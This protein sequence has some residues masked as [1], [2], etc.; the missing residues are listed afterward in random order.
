M[1]SS[2]RSLKRAKSLQEQTYLAIRNSILSGEITP[3]ERL[4]ETQL[5]KKLQVSRTP[6]REAIKQLQRETLAIADHNGGIRVATISVT[7]AQQLY[8]CRIALE[9]LAVKEVCQQGTAA[10]IKKIEIWVEKAEHISEDEVLTKDQSLQMLEIDYQFHLAIV[11]AANNKWLVY[12]LDQ[13]FDKMKLL[14]IQTTQ[15]NPKVLEIRT[16]HRQVYNAISQRNTK[17]AIDL[18]TKHLRASK[19]R[20]VKELEN[21]NSKSLDI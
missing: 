17:Q 12:L 18:I 14:R 20:V 6:V 10:Q 5:A 13:V 1:S 8:D 16:E 9:E 11:E 2:L 3:G 4:I 21:I 7:D 19:K 15:Y